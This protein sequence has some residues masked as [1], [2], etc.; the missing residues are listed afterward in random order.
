MVKFITYDIVLNK[1][2]P[3][4]G[5]ITCIASS[6]RA[7]SKSNILFAGESGVVFSVNDEKFSKPYPL[8]KGNS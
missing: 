5:G 6:W 3:I 4:E 2:E 1:T 7:N 8:F